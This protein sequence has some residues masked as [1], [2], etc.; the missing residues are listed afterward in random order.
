MQ[1]AAAPDPRTSDASSTGCAGSRR[2]CTDNTAPKR[3]ALALFSRC[4]A[5]ELLRPAEASRIRGAPREGEQGLSRSVIGGD[6]YVPHATQFD[7]QVRA[8]SGANELSQRSAPFANTSVTLGFIVG[9][10]F[11]V[12]A[13]VSTRI[14][15]RAEP[16]VGETGRGFGGPHHGSPVPPMN[17]TATSLCRS[18]V[19]ACHTY[20]AS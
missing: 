11:E 3:G 9:S 13:L 12:M 2:T 14:Q 6:V 17:G 4:Q 10:S 15:N 18:T 7:F 20:I 19:A 5:R 1:P 16:P 8:R